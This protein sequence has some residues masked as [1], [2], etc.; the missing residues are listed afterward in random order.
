MVYR[1]PPSSSPKILISGYGHIYLRREKEFNCKRGCVSDKRS[2]TSQ[3]QCF[4]SIMG[5]QK[6]FFRLRRALVVHTINLQLAE[7]S[8]YVN[9]NV[10][11][12]MY[13][14]CT[15]GSSKIS[16]PPASPDALRKWILGFK[17]S[18]AIWIGEDS[19]FATSQCTIC[20]SRAITLP[21]P[22]G[23]CGSALRQCN[24]L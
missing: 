19:N 16:V 17:D 6:I 18:I 2:E 9:V 10:I 14:I 22:A 3:K 13:I 23:G 20:N 12:R 4:L 15:L 11:N 21:C 1:L 5:H 8:A 7:P 24:F